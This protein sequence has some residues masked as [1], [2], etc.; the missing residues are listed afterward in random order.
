MPR[1]K[2]IR[3]KTPVLAIRL[4]E[5][6]ARD[7]DCPYA[8]RV[9]CVNAIAVA[10][11]VLE[12]ELV[13]PTAPRKPRGASPTAAPPIEE[14]IV[15]ALDEDIGQKMLRALEESHGA[16]TKGDGRTDQGVQ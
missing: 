2:Y 9:F 3:P 6:I 7:K 10:T 14:P 5:E 4:W 15:E 12:M 11:K 1:K 8:Y 16:D 13:L